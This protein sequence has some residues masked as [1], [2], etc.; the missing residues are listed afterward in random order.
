MYA[1]GGTGKW[2]IYGNGANL[3]FSDNESAGSVVFDRNV[4]ANG[5]LDVTGNLTSATFI[6]VLGSAGTSDQGLEVRS[7]SGQTTNT[8]K[9]IRVRNNSNSDTFSV[10]YTG[11]VNSTGITNS[12]NLTTNNIYLFDDII[13]YIIT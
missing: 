10:S 7:N 12:G 2:D 3:R 13:C 11:R 4:D 8:N 9:A 6:Q 5:G 1:G